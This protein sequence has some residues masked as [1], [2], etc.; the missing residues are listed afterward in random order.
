[1][2]YEFVRGGPSLGG[3]VFGG[4]TNDGDEGALDKSNPL[5]CTII[6]GDENVTTEAFDIATGEIEIEVI[7][8][9]ISITVVE[10]TE[11]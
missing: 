8:G 7:K 1:M 9:D 4:N 11:E 10:P 6:M 3:I 2:G 5:V